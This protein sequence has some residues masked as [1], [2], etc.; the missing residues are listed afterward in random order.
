MTQMFQ[1]KK[2]IF[3]LLLIISSLIFGILFYAIYNDLLIIKFSSATT[4]SNLD[5]N[6]EKKK[7][8][9]HFFN[10]NKWLT[11]EKELIDSNQKEKTINYLATA[12]LNL[13]NDEKIINQIVSVQS[14]MLDK[15]QSEA[16]I[17]FDRSFLFQDSS[18]NQKLYIIQSILKTIA[19]NLS[20]IKDVRFLVGHKIMQDTHLDFSHSWPVSGFLSN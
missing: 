3:Y 2:L 11:E 18:V 13:L 8:K 12:W 10:K 5:L 9:I 4:N 16:Y 7:F 19:Q 15:A 6:I 14:V 17:S 20:Q 1:N